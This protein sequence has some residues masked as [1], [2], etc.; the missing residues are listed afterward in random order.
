MF[1]NKI[2]AA[3]GLAA[4]IT[5]SA[6][7]Q[8]IGGD[9]TMRDID[10]DEDLVIF[11]G[12]IS[13]NGRV[14]GEVRIFGGDI[15]LDLDVTE[16]VKVVGGEIDF[17]GRAGGD[18]RIAGGNVEFDATVSGDADF[19][20]GIMD[21]SG[22]VMGMTRAGAGTIDIHNDFVAGEGI[23]AAGEEIMFHGSSAGNVNFRANEIFVDGVIEGNL[24]TRGD[25]VVILP[26]ARISGSLNHRGPEAP[27]I[28]DGAVI[29][30]EIDF[31]EAAYDSDWEDFHDLDLD[32]DFGPVG[33]ILGVAFIASA[34]LLGLLAS[35]LAP[36]GVARIAREFRVRPFVSGM[37]G[38]VIFAFSPVILVTLIILLALTVIGIPLAVLAAALYLPFL[39]LAYAFGAIALGD[40]I[41]N[42]R[43]TRLGLGLRA[44]SLLVVLIAVAAIGVV[45]MLGFTAGL[46]LMCIGLG[47][48]VLA[49]GKREPAPTAV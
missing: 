37:L 1:I 44:L 3:V 39:F 28:R 47:A 32:F 14:D 38:L 41:F 26:G 33:D 23:D 2:I 35:L 42:R 20:G 16:D 43:N 45:P 7:A 27:E 11:A 48:W 6:G 8:F 21:L 18:L 5:A 31:L 17:S 40:L 49:L 15:A 30:G 24:K 10:R 9:I 13:V 34:V 12:D 46:I 4:V 22:E 25:R 29:G 19:A 36:N